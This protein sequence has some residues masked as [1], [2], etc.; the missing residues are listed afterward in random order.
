MTAAE[1]RALAG[2]C[3]LKA[4]VEVETGSIQPENIA[5]GVTWT[6]MAF[7]REET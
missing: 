3:G 4:V 2:A 6:R 1:T 7:V 5:S